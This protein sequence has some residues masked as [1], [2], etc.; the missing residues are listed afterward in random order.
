VKLN[1]KIKAFGIDCGN[2]LNFLNINK[3]NTN[4]GN[5]KLIRVGKIVN[6]FYIK[7]D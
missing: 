5:R 1:E 2:N 6:N 3:Y 7:N 4:Q